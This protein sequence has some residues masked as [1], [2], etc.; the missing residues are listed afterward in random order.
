[1]AVPKKAT[2]L[3]VA[4]I[5]SIIGAQTGNDGADEGLEL[6]EE[7]LGLE[8]GVELGTLVVGEMVGWLES[9]QCRKSV[10]VGVVETT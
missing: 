4:L 5:P 8:E 3:E 2:E 10:S 7:E 1:L 9:L 6:G